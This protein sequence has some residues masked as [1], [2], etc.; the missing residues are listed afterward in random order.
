MSRLHSPGGA[1]G[2]PRVLHFGK[3]YPPHR[4]GME[5][6]V[7]GLCR[8]LAGRGFPCGAV[9]A[10]DRARPRM[11]LDRGVVVER[12]AAFG[13]VRSLPLCPRAPVAL[14]GREVD[15]IHLHHPNPLAD[16]AC[17]L[18]DSAARVVVTYHSDIVRQRRLGGLHAP[19]LR[20]TLR[21]ADAVVATSAQYADSSAALAPFREKVR[22]IPLGIEPPALPPLSEPFA[23]PGREPRY[24]FIGR[25]VPYKGLPVLIRALRLARGRAWVVGAGPR[26]RQLRALA[27]DEGVTP[28]VEFLGEVS[29]AEKLRRLARCDALVLP[30]LTRAEAFGIV[31]LEA[32]AAGRPVIVSDLPTGVRMLVEDGATG[33]RF[34]PGDA[35]ALAAAM[36]CLAEDPEAA[37]R[38]GSEGRRR[39][40]ER[41]TLDRMVEGHVRLYR[42]LCGIEAPKRAELR[43][44]KRA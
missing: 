9:V 32:M 2:E 33:L 7:A 19:L 21:R 36:R 6:V 4:G 37:R 20:H 13:A 8:G 17:L 27:R 41:Y 43:S 28:R 14:R 11:D 35:T 39:F 12:M 23:G 29:E 34:P 42:E 25:L 26:Q 10:G 24:L 18:S 40:H 3:Y 15:V 1:P 31:I 44:A 22:V 5:T 16:L 30:S 38:M